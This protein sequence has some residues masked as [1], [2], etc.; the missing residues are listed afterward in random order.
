[1]SIGMTKFRSHAG[2][3]HVCTRR[4]NCEQYFPGVFS[5]TKHKH[6]SLLHRVSITCRDPP[7]PLMFVKGTLNNA[8][9][10]IQNIDQT[11]HLSFL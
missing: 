1:M 2:D 7:T 6:R 5:P 11:V 9:R 10:Y 3:G 8:I 4:R